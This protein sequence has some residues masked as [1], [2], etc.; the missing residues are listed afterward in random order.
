MGSGMGSNGMDHGWDHGWDP[1]KS[2]QDSGQADPRKGEQR[3]DL[4]RTGLGKGKGLRDIPGNPK[5][6]LRL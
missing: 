1:G 6:L 5:S 4:N 2:P 3:Q